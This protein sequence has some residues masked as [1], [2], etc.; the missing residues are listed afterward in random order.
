[1]PKNKEDELWN[2][3]HA[4]SPLVN[5]EEVFKFLTSCSISSKIPDN[6]ENRRAAEH[7]ISHH[8]EFAYRYAH[9]KVWGETSHLSQRYTFSRR[10][11]FRFT[12]AESHIMKSPWWAYRYARDIIQ[13]RWKEAEPFIATDAEVSFKYAVLINEAFPAGEKN[14]LG[15]NFKY[16]Y[17]ELFK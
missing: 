17:Q 3:L 1:M 8:P 4:D 9:Y 10:S 15:T 7:Y 14:I 13:G 16:R 6:D 12:I 2:I 5:E 11:K